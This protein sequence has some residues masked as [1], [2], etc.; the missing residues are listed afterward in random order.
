MKNINLIL[1]RKQMQKAIIAFSALVMLMSVMILPSSAQIITREK[2]IYL[3][4]QLTSTNTGA[5]I[6]DHEVYI[7]SDSTV[8]GGFGYYGVTKT[9]VNGFFRDTMTTTT[10][11]GVINIHV[12]DFDNNL[13]QLDRYYR[14]VWDNE[15]LMFADLA[16]FD[17]DANMELQANFDPQ[18]DTQDDPMKVIFKD[19]SI[20]ESI[21]SWFWDF[22]DG[23]TST[24]QDPEHTYSKSGIFLVTLTINSLPPGYV[25]FE[26][27]TITKQVQLGLRE[28][29]RVGGHI[30]AQQ[31]PIDHGIA[32]L[33]TYDE[34]NKLVLLDT[35]KA[36]YLGY[37]YFYE[38]PAGKYYT[39][40]RLEITD[41]L[42]GQ[43]MPTYFRNTYIWNEAEEIVINDV[44][45]FE[46]DIW[47]RPT[48]G[49]VT[50][51]GQI[52]GQ[53]TYDTSLARTPIPAGDIEI[54]LLNTQ[55]D[56]LTCKLSNIAGQFSFGSIPYGTYQ[57]Y[58]DVTGISTTSM[59]VTLTEDKPNEENLN[60]IIF[61]NE[62]TFAISENNSDFIENT[63]LL[64]PNP[65][66]DQARISFEMKKPSGIEIQITD[67]A[68][69]TVYSGTSMLSEGKQDITLPV[70][71]LPAGVYQVLLIPEDHVIM[72]GKF[73]KL[74]Q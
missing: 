27:S 40:A 50:G 11:D 33:Y 8:N 45:N 63:M 21:K 10:S 14:F 19:M 62:I 7:L 26:S 5:P 16:I 9:D 4:G 54:I 32:Y 69:K 48:S 47:L 74:K 67:M 64:Y 65:A 38:V 55:G 18:I 53:I 6:A 15:Y 57:L 29:H 2:F 13:I 73:L 34:S 51:E 46:C 56:F 20:G 25:G 22:G 39:K 49:I 70:G 43:F 28:Y 35:T 30:F 3:S 59:Y 31:F 66:T 68:G 12:F 58:P 72:T 36:D 52:T 37:Y 61:P 44:D 23:S 60:L 1:K 41:D 42:Y 71:K 24:V 17:P